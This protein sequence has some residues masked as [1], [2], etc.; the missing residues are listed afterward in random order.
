MTIGGPILGRRFKPV[1]QQLGIPRRLQAIMG[2][3][4][5]LKW[6][7]E[8]N[9]GHGDRIALELLLQYNKGDVM[10]LKAPRKKL[11]EKLRGRYPT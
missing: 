1:K 4:G 3:D 7:W 11:G 8:Q 6:W 2:W 5:V 10:N 9:Y